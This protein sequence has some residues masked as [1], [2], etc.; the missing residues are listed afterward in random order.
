MS[1]PLEFHPDSPSSSPLVD[2][3]WR[4]LRQ[5]KPLAAWAS[6]QRALTVDPHCAPA[7]DAVERL[8]NWT[9]LPAAARAVYRFQAP[10]DAGRRARWDVRFQ[11]HSLTDLESAAEAFASLAEE[12][13]ADA[14]AWH[15]LA[16]CHAWIGR[17]TQAIHCL[18]R[19]V[20][21]IAET[22][23]D[24]AAEAWTLA[25]VLRFGTEALA[26]ADDL[27]TALIVDGRL[28]DEQDQWF[29]RWPNL[30]RV[31]LPSTPSL[32]G[33]STGKE[34]VFEWL[35]RPPPTENVNSLRAMDLPRVIGTIIRTPALLRVSTLDPRN[36]SV[37]EDP[38]YRE[39][40]QLLRE[41]RREKAP[42]AIN[43]ADSELGTF[44]FP[45]G[46]E[47]D[48]RRELSRKV[49]ESY[50]EDRWIHRP[51]QALEGLTPLEAARLVADGDASLR[52]QLVG[53]VRF[54]EQL[55]RRPTHSLLYQGYPFDRLR[56]RLGL[57]DRGEG[58]VDPDDLSCASA[59]VLDRL[60][61][62]GLDDHGL[63]DAF[64]SANALANDAL[65]GRFAAEIAQRDLFPSSR[66]NREEVYAPLVR[67]AMQE[68]RPGMALDWLRKA[69]SQS[70][71]QSTQTFALWTAEI[72][73]RAGMPLEALQ[74]YRELL[75]L[76]PSGPA[77]ALDGAETLLDNNQPD[78]A[79]ILL[80]EAQVR[81][82]AHGDQAA[83]MRIEHYLERLSEA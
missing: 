19:E 33:I 23:S 15:N 3:G 83:L 12:D 64:L 50:F 39:I 55:G 28:N 44:R 32:T 10:G 53:V 26:L 69:I 58:A 17:N 78:Q 24:Q 7:R 75:L 74:V 40:R 73:A 77:L 48:A 52:A 47:S 36:F 61:L 79:L 37:L 6:W 13:A 67:L 45:V 22:K 82:R 35:D 9:E 60:G 2:E 63:I 46:L 5:Q 30:V 62:D 70:A 42:L 43:A 81:A 8:E 54:R 49:I 31:D 76:S 14:Q 59:L 38:E 56:N 4:H 41:A 1:N 11:G 21:L 66:M 80:Q 29:S 71:G 51:R 65:T 68:G 72:Y 34:E 25:E 57:L 27:R 20:S 18:K 16:L